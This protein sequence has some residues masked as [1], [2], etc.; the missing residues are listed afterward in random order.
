MNTS[1]KKLQLKLQHTQRKLSRAESRVAFLLNEMAEKDAIACQREKSNGAKINE[2][3]SA[4][5][6]ENERLNQ[7]H[8]RQLMA[9][10]ILHGIVVR[11][12]GVLAVR[13]PLRDE[14]PAMLQMLEDDKLNAIILSI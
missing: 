1:I 4:I 5:K 7:L 3:T 9:M 12:G 13:R 11:S 8:N 2:L 10:K 14:P 6:V